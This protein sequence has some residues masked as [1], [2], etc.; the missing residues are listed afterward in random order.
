[1]LFA[2]TYLFHVTD[3][4]SSEV[5][6]RILLNLILIIFIFITR[7]VIK[8][9]NKIAGN[10]EMLCEALKSRVFILHCDSV[11]SSSPR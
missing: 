2:L 4:F 9:L 8:C 6:S 1:M 10:Y 7:V 5:Y 3:M 11:F